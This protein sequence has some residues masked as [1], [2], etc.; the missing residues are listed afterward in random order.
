MQLMPSV[1]LIEII[2]NPIVSTV[3]SRFGWTAIDDSLE[4]ANGSRRKILKRVRRPYR[5]AIRVGTITIKITIMKKTIIV[6][7]ACI[8][9]MCTV[10]AQKNRV[11][12]TGGATISNYKVTADGGDE[13]GNSKTGFTLGL[14]ANLAAGK[15]FM[16][17]PGVHWVQKGT[18]DEQDNGG[19]PEK[20]SLIVNVI[21][22]PVNFLYTSGGV[23][24][25]AGA[26]LS[27]L[28]PRQFE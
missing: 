2:T 16:I 12:F 4:Q 1:A 15:N 5:K 19:G 21:E 11:G 7:S 6:L 13:T 27:F 20:I 9:F 17:Q 28:A 3:N 18:K 23:F 10:T 8:L 14:I 24:I 25:G 26:N 22:V